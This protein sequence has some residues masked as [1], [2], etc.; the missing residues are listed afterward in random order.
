MAGKLP[1]R[2]F[3]RRRPGEFLRKEIP[4]APDARLRGAATNRPQ[5]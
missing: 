2:G 1:Q 5:A 4:P 3:P